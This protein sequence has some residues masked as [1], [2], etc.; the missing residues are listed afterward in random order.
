MTDS[1]IKKSL[2]DF[3]SKLILASFS[4]FQFLRWPILPQYMDIYYHIQSGWG[5]IKAGGYSGWDFWQCA[6]VG[7]PNIYPPVF[8]II[9]AFLMKLG[10]D[11]IIIAKT[12]EAAAPVLFLAILWLFIRNNYGQRLAFFVLVA[13]CSSFS[14]YLV[15]MNHIPAT[16]AFIFGFLAA[17]L[18]LGG[19]VLRAS[20]L[21]SLAFY[22]HIGVS[23]F[24][25]LAVILY[26]IYIKDYR[27]MPVIIA[28]V[29]ILSLPMTA[30]YFFRINAIS[31]AGLLINEKY[32]SQIK[33]LD[34]AFAFFGLILSARA[35]GKYLFFLSLLL[36]SLIFLFYPYRFFSGEGYLPVM[37]LAAMAIAY[38]FE[39]AMGLKQVLRYAVSLLIIFLLALSPTLAFD[40]PEGPGQMRCG[41]KLYDSAF[42]NLLLANKEALWLPQYY[43]PAARIIK[44]NSSDSDIIYSSMDI[45]GVALAGISGR[46]TAN[47]LL[48]EVE[49]GRYFDPLKESKIIIFT[50]S[51]SP[52]K[53]RQAVNNYGLIKIGEENDLFIF[54]KNPASRAKAGIRRAQVPFYMIIMLFLLFILLFW[55]AEILEKKYLT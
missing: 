15:L 4:F 49:A 25:F 2:W 55:K 1:I 54:Y 39:K 29:L 20:L 18:I 32:F 14:F 43:L 10:V 12:A 35:K 46:A 30:G 48:P 47:R 26:L 53:I 50:Q 51:D 3:G 5:F 22:T 42:Q 21:L 41:F 40:K 9:I 17:D 6:P 19:S 37:L 13:S 45:I 16:L 52:E 11:P 31:P 33:L 28:T 34:Y 36:A 44:D 24:L 8:H 38:I 27:R 23:L 7:R